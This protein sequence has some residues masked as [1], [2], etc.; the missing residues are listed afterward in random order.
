MRQVLI[1][2]STIT[3]SL[4]PCVTASADLYSLD[5]GTAWATYGVNFPGRTSQT[6]YLNT[7]TLAPGDTAINKIQ[8][9]FG[10]PFGTENLLGLGFTALLYSDSNGGTPWDATLVWSGAGTISS[11]ANNFVEVAVPDVG[12]AG[13]FAVGFLFTTP[14]DGQ[15]YHPASADISSQVANR[16]YFAYSAPDGTLDLNDLTGTAQSVGT[17]EIGGYIPNLMIRA[18]GVPAPGAV[19]LLGILGLLSRHRRR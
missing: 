6:V 14:A 18:N 12:V 1:V 13:S 15:Q 3:C 19:A 11:L 16:S 4:A 17:F 9:A 7:F 8:I 10:M 2:A 5:D